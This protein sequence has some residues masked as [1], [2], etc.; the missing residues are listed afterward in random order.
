MDTAAKSFDPDLED[1][2]HSSPDDMDA[3]SSAAAVPACREASSSTGLVSLSFMR[4]DSGPVILNPAYRSYSG[5]VPDEYQ[6]GDNLVLDAFDSTALTSDELSKST[7]NRLRHPEL[8]APSPFHHPFSS[9]ASDLHRHSLDPRFMIDQSD[10]DESSFSSSDDSC[11]SAGA[12]RTRGALDSKIYP[13]PENNSE[14][15][16]LSSASS[17]PPTPQAASSPLIHWVRSRGKTGQF[18]GWGEVEV[19]ISMSLDNARC[20]SQRIAIITRRTLN[21]ICGV[22]NSTDDD[23]DSFSNYNKVS[24]RSRS[25]KVPPPSPDNPPVSDVMRSLSRSGR[26]KLGIDHLRTVLKP[27]EEPAPSPWVAPSNSNFQCAYVLC[28]YPT[29]SSGSWKTVTK[30]TT[31]G[32]RDWLPYIGLTFCHA[33]WTQFRTR[34]TLERLGRRP[35]EP[36]PPPTNEVI[37]APVTLPPKSPRLPASSPRLTPRAIKSDSPALKSTP[38]AKSQSPAL[39]PLGSPKLAPQKAQLPPGCFQE[40]KSTASPRLTPRAIKSDSPALKST[41]KAKSQSPALKPL[42]S[43]KLAPQKAQLPPGCFQ[44]PQSPRPSAGR[45]QAG[46]AHTSPAIGSS[47]RP[48]GSPLSSRAAASP[49]ASRSD[50][51]DMEP[52]A[53]PKKQLSPRR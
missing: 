25:L 40:P 43:P 51:P 35:D 48:S 44:E 6:I 20:V 29:K 21:E 5:N 9:F 46:A 3:M 32:Q 24:I 8:P 50:L 19:K 16:P 49:R 42:G 37:R 33:C 27:A 30:D 23:A 14:L 45:L 22:S 41:P 38:K 17:S 28:P 47:P 39:K 4:T 31:A 26:G 52:L 1:S 2:G 53:L 15:S 7:R 11:T 36:P 18:L 10:F 13:Y 34:G 12:K